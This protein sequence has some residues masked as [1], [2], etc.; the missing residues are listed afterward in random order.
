MARAVAVFAFHPDRRRVLAAIRKSPGKFVG[1]WHVPGG[2]VE[3]SEREAEAAVRELR[4]ETGVVQDVV[5]FIGQFQDTNERGRYACSAFMA[6]METDFIPPNPEPDH[7]A[8]WGWH[9][10]EQLDNLMPGTLD[11]YRLA[12]A[13]LLCTK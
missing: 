11:M 12:L 7:N 5:K 9:D 3:T 1:M 6:K 2:S 4:E 13:A 10:I 8:G